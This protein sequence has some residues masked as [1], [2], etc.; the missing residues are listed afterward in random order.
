MN[1]AGETFMELDEAL[2]LIKKMVKNNA[3]NDTRHID[4]GLVPADQ[5]THYEKALKVAKLAI[6]EGKITQDEF[7]ARVHLN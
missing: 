2:G 1:R 4:L 3:T 6:K 5:R 7:T